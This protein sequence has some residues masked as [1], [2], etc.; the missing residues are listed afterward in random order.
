MKRR[1]Q[2][3]AREL[4]NFVRLE[5]PKPDD[6]FDGAGSGDWELVAEIWA[7]IQDILPSRSEDV[8][9]GIVTSTRRARL[10]MRARDDVTPNMRFVKGVR[11][12]HIVSG[13]ADL[14]GRPAR[15]EFMVE[16]LSLIHI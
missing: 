8:D 12:M 16:D 9:N 7:G 6:G 1:D 14:K 4:D 2:S 15:Q 3:T 11:I 5:K 10:R 13:P